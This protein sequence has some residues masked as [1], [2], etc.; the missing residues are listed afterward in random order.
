L[1]DLFIFMT[2]LPKFDPNKGLMLAG[3]GVVISGLS[4]EGINYTLSIAPKGDIAAFA[5][6][7]GVFFFGI[8]MFYDGIKIV[9]KVN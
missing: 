1:K 5:V 4:A 7:L 2:I 3:F 8:Q 6:C 9:Y